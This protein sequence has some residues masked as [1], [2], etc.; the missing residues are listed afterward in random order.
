[1]E[2]IRLL[3]N[4]LPI[5]QFLSKRQHD[6]PRF[7]PGLHGGQ[8]LGAVKVLAA[9]GGFELLTLPLEQIPLGAVEQICA[10]VG[11]LAGME[12]QAAPMAAQQL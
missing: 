7:G 3:C 11:H 10:G 1:M 6:Q 12:L 2:Q 8:Q 4:T 9:A 5:N